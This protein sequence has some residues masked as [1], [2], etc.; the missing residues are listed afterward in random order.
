[1]ELFRGYLRTHEKKAQGKWGDGD[2]ITLERAR[3]CD[4]YAG[5]LAPNVC[6]LDVDDSA[7]SEMVMQMV[8]DL[9]L[10]CMVNQ[11]TRGRHFFFRNDGALPK[12]RTHARI[13]CGL[14]ADFKIGDSNSYAILK[15]GGVERFTEW[16][17]ETP[18]ELDPLP[19]FLR[20]VTGA[21]HG[22]VTMGAGDGRNSALFGYILTLQRNG[23]TTEQCRETIRVI[24]RYILKDPLG[25]DELETV[26]RDDAFKQ[27][28]FF[29]KGKF[30]H[31]VFATFLSAEERIIKVNGALHCYE[32]GVYVAGNK[33]IEA[34]MLK[35]I[36]SLKDTQ[37]KEVLKYLDVSLAGQTE[38]ADARYIAF[39]NGIL[40][41]VT[42]ELL[43]FSPELVVTNRIGF[44]Y[45][46]D[47]YDELVDRTLNKLSCGDLDVRAV[48]EECAGYCLY[49][50]NELGK[51][52]IL[53]G[54]KSNGKSTFLAMVKTMLGSE[55]VSAL[56]LSELGDR[57]Y[58][59][60]MFGKL[61][62]IGD[63][64]SDDFLKGQEVAT[65]K[66]I[67]TGDRMKAEMKG[68]T[69]SSS[70]HTLNCCSAPTTS[71]GCAT[72]PARW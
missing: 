13:A 10:N 38:C 36:P 44:D 45:V 12:S 19:M 55:N 51:A 47:A 28:A 34:K 39:N 65:F 40:D 20:P 59:A 17:P 16:E 54:D 53:T 30:L 56:D 11:T 48:L 22:F 43:D 26:L 8:E 35:H 62:N 29:V 14:D 33:R 7:A 71:H 72:R 64:I 42:N 23:F 9:Q 31:D 4:E 24:N 58:S 37:R 70:S 32:G 18:G 25:E 67:V 15:F 66:K 1:M 21:N 61:A 46:S 6:L 2:L 3:R 49:R 68:K 57:F 60:M 52:F 41:I 50:R 27:P 69:R 63:D 5:V